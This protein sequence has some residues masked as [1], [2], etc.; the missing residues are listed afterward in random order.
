MAEESAAPG[1]PSGVALDMLNAIGEEARLPLS[2]QF[3]PW[4]RAQKMVLQD[5]STVIAPLTRTPE[6]ESRYL[7]ITHLFDYH[8]V[9]LTRSPNKPPATIA[10]AADRRIGVLRSSAGVDLLEKLG[11]PFDAG[12]TE[13][14]NARKLAAGRIDV[15]MVPDVVVLPSLRRAQLDPGSFLVG[16][17]V[18]EPGS[19][20]LAA[21]PAF[22]PILAK[23]LQDAAARASRQKKLQAILLR[24][25]LPN[26]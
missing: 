26:K 10:E 6:R 4:L 16:G 21:S 25:R 18:G 3:L 15:W 20:Y 24:Y 22:D 9:L 12:E 23:R 13:I 1:T 7:W 17:I 11:I 2:Y 8:L 5:P 19:V 14:L